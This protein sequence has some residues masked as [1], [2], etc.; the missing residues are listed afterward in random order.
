[1]SLKLLEPITFSGLRVKN[2]IVMPPMGMGYAHE[3]GT[4][5]DRVIRYYL[6]RAQS[7][8]GMIV[9][10]NCIVDPDV[11]GVGPEL[12]IHDDR[13]IE[14]LRRLVAALK[15]YEVVVGLQLNHMGRQTTLGTPIAP[16]PIPISPKGP[17]PRVLTPEEI[18]FV[19]EEFVEGARRAREAGFDFVELHGAHGYLIC[20][21]LSP[22]SNRRD[23]EYGGS[24]EGRLRFL[25]EIIAGIQERVGT[26]FPIQVRIS[27]Q[28]Y[29]SDGLTLAETREIARRLEQA[30]VSSISVS[31][32]N[33]QTLHYI[34]APMFMPK[35]YLAEDAGAI[36]SAVRIPVIAVGRLHDVEVAER[37]LQEGKADLIAV[38]RGL[39]ADPEWA[40]KVIE[41]R[42][43]DIR[44]CISCN[45][46]VDFVSRALEARCTVNAELGEE[47]V[48]QIRPARQRK[49]ILIIG[50]GPA[51]LEAARVAAER[52]HEVWLFE[53]ERR[54]G[55]KLHVS[56]AA[57][58][59]KEI[60][61]FTE[62][63]IR[64]IERHH[65]RVELGVTLAREELLGMHPDVVV[66]ATGSVPMIPPLSGADLPI[67]AIAE[68]VLLGRTSVGR[69][70]VIVGGGGTGCDVAEY[71]LHRGHEITIVELLSHIGRGIEAITRRWLY[72]EFKEAGVQLLTRHRI[73]RIEEGRAVVVDERDQE[74]ILPCDSVVLAMGYRPSDEMAFCL[75]EDFPV[76]VYRIGDC[77][78]PGTILDAVA[79]GAHLAAKL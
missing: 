21:F 27:G 62:Y 50:G 56:A 63:L 13:Y 52:G 79:Q 42:I 19:V 36:K 55:G 25:L 61:R 34:M 3:D 9:V 41:N 77:V 12:R 7:G 11:V 5:S 4:V 53:K 71:L 75:E 1:M 31:A 14:G 72:Y 47:F 28:E 65:V 30:G 10:E 23:D 64:Q 2:R 6:R 35:G 59:K 66:L 76:P 37:V 24:L 26:D 69:R 16:S 33:W 60:H 44:P 70:V 29:V 73:A 40:K 68:E 32:G 51:G 54:L 45:Y 20:E 17:I 22:A 78:R 38:G 48:F 67:V 74:R 15:P 58:S 49:R 39:I 46:C 57:P 43:E 18:R 8:V